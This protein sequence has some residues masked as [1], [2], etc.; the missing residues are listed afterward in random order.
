MRPMMPARLWPIGYN[1]PNGNMDRLRSLGSF[2]ALSSVS[3]SLHPWLKPQSSKPCFLPR[4]GFLETPA[5]LNGWQGKAGCGAAGCLCR[6]RK[7]IHQAGLWAIS[8]FERERWK[9]SA[10]SGALEFGFFPRLFFSFGFRPPYGG[11][12]VA[13]FRP[14]LPRI[15]S[16]HLP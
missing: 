7:R 12:F 16:A 10:P 2:A 14:E 9:R 13:G 8:Q 15:S 4:L 1:V 5:M 3:I 6:A 11:R